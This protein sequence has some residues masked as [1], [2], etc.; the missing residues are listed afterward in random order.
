MTASELIE[1]TVVEE[2]EFITLANSVGVVADKSLSGGS[3][4]PCT[5]PEELT[6]IPLVS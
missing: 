4:V 3:H 1:L 2:L 5:K 6:P